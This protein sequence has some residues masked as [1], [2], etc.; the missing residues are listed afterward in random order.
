MDK[1]LE[2]ISDLFD[3]EHFE[4]N[5]ND[6][7]LFDESKLIDG[8]GGDVDC[9]ASILKQFDNEQ[10]NCCKV[11]GSTK[12]MD[13]LSNGRRNNNRNNWTPLNDLSSESEMDDDDQDNNMDS[14][15][16]RHY[17]KH[18]QPSSMF[19]D[20]HECEM[21]EESIANIDVED[22]VNG[23]LFSNNENRL[24]VLV[25]K[26]CR[27][28]EQ[29]QQKSD[30]LCKHHGAIR[31]N[32]QLPNEPCFTLSNQLK[33]LIYNSNRLKNQNYFFI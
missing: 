31:P 10:I 3:S 22:F 7:L 17:S 16:Q 11:N 14:V 20:K 24:S 19:D 13:C 15:H 25:P 12:S 32:K 6:S 5:E 1:Q 23:R 4:S 26:R 30:N 29:K 18:T 33:T 28:V 21:V 9:L 27:L 8:N 2:L